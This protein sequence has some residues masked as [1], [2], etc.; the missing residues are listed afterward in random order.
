M[1]QVMQVMDPQKLKDDIKAKEYI[2]NMW[3]FAGQH[4]YYATHPVFL[5]P[6]AV[7]ILVCNLSKD[8]NK[9]AEPCVRA[10]VVKPL[11]NPNRETNLE[12]LL[13]WLV[14]VHRLQP[15]KN[16]VVCRSNGK[17]YYVRP[18][19]F[20]VGTYADKP[21]N[22]VKEMLECIKRSLTETKNLQSHVVSRPILSID[23]SRTLGDDDLKKL[24]EKIQEVLE[25]EPY[26]GEKIPI[27]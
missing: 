8:L 27:R 4:L 11:Q 23:N 20:V 10:G 18:P 19:V 5:S 12:N 22:D 13:S 9:V 15:K 2:L 3:D 16:D 6:R 26:M 21:A 7:Y 17:Q 25:L 14:A 24:R 1:K